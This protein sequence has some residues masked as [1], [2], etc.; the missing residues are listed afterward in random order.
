[1]KN[2]EEV[3]EIL[4]NEKLKYSD[5]KE[6]IT[7]L[8]CPDK[9]CDLFWKEN[10]ACPCEYD[11]PSVEDMKK[12]LYVRDMENLL[13][14]D[15]DFSSL[16]TVDYKTKD[17]CTRVHFRNSDKHRIMYKMPIDDRQE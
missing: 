10:C 7:Y 3:K 8:L 4:E 9:T 11:C 14:L 2:L 16:Q 1:M 13:V 17:G 6:D 12:I 15:G 5:L